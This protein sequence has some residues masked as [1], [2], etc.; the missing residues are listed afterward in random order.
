MDKE[1]KQKLEEMIQDAKAR[2]E[3]YK[4]LAETDLEIDETEIDRA[5]LDTPKIHSRWNNY[6]SSETL[7]LN[8]VVQLREAV[9]LERWKY[10]MGKQ[11]D[12]YYAKNGIVH[13]KILKTDSDRYMNAD[14]KMALV[15]ELYVTQKTVVEF[16]ERTIKEVQSRNFHCRVAV[17]WRKFVSGV[18]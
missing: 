17:D 10:Y 3:K 1:S 13:E 16:I 7:Y 6:F 12:Q 2:L 15:Q 14:P 9:K 11:T 5:V 8:S 18:N 4:G